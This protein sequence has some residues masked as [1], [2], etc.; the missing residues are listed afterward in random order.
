[1]L[2]ILL[3]V[4]V[5]VICGAVITRNKSNA[6]DTPAESKKQETTVSSHSITEIPQKSQPKQTTFTAELVEPPKCSTPPVQR[7]SKQP[8]QFDIAMFQ[9]LRNN[10]VEFIDNRGKNGALWIVGGSSLSDIAQE[11]KYRFG[12]TFT[13][14]PEGGQCTKHRP[15]WWTR[16]YASKSAVVTDAAPQVLHSKKTKQIEG[17][18]SIEELLTANPVPNTQS[19][20]EQI[21]NAIKRWDEISAQKDKALKEYAELEEL[22]T[23]HKKELDKMLTNDQ[24]ELAVNAWLLSSNKAQVMKDLRNN[25][26]SIVT[27]AAK[28]K[29]L[30]KKIIDNC[31]EQL[32]LVSDVIEQLSKS[33]SHF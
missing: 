7:Q 30:T 32:S 24:I 10:G 2:I 23:K 15:A 29:S 9:F 16:N 21:D 19:N 1:M 12:V 31:N 33:T 5:L 11:C 28:S 25:T 22:Y 6:H 8:V 26:I 27:K 14:K 3:L 13:F 18:T 4:V 17:Q 20:S